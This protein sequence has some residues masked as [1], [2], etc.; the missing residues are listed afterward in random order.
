MIFK[1]ELV[2]MQTKVT[3]EEVRVQR[4]EVG[5]RLSYL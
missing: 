1:D 3:T 5:E 4:R 2:G